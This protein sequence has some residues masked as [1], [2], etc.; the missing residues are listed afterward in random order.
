M[1][2]VDGSSRAAR[3]C[4]GL[5]AGLL[6]LCAGHAVPAEPPSGT[7]AGGS[8]NPSASD[9][10]DLAPRGD[11]FSSLRQGFA[12]DLQR[13]VVRGHF[14]VSLPSGTQRYYCLIDPKTGRSEVY[15]VSGQLVSRRDGMTGIKGAAVTVYRC[16][17]AEQKGILVTA[18]Y[19]LSGSAGSKNPL[20][21]P[22]QH[23]PE[24]TAPPAARSAAAPAQAEVLA[25]YMRFIDGQNAHDRAAISQ[26]L[27]DS[28]DFVW[29][30]YDGHSVW[31]Y[32]EALDAFERA[33][34]GT[35]KLDPQLTDLRIAEVSPG[36]AVLVTP[37]L[38][39]GGSSGDRP[40]AVPVRW[41]GL[42]LKTKS[43]WRLASIFVTPFE[44]D[45]A[46]RLSKADS[47]RR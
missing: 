35:R 3:R 12:Q 33:W 9:A 46:Q 4:R 29:A 24:A 47:L 30:E 20:P 28:K 45:P 34:T 41:A 11:F 2:H 13:E 10:Q 31:G 44:S 22:V 21:A 8:A 5:A 37:L 32:K 19:L 18:G 23:P 25:V 17:D 26:V 42:F 16:A 43:G 39:T 38:L 27:L 7:A 14:D 40:P 36:V 6:L 1:K 15:G